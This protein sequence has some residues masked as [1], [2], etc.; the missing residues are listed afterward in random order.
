[1]M[2]QPSFVTKNQTM[3][4]LRTIEYNLYSMTLSS[5]LDYSCLKYNSSLI[6]IN[7]TGGAII[8]GRYTKCSDRT[9]NREI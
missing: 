7:A 5:S 4:I 9:L 6:D 8:E 3:M 2:C 1:M